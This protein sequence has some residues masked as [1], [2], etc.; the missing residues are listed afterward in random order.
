[1]L[2]RRLFFVFNII[3]VLSLL[4][5]GGDYHIGRA[6]S[7]FIYEGI[8]ITLWGDGSESAGEEKIAY[9][10]S[11]NQNGT[12]QLIIDDELLTSMGGPVTHNRQEMLVTGVWLNE[13]KT[14]QVQSMTLAEGKP[15]SP[16]GIFGPQPW[17]SILCKFSDIPA[18]P[19]DL[20]YFQEMYSS[21][22]PGL[23]HFWRQNS[24]D[25][26]NLEGSGAFGWY[27]LP[28]ERAYYLP[29]GNFDWWTA[30]ADCTAAADPYVDFTPYI[31]INLMF[32]DLLDC[33]A[34]GGGWYACLDGLCQTWRMTWEPP[35]GYQ[36]IGV[37]AHETGHGFGLPHSLGN[38]QQGYDNRWDV[39]SDVWSNGSDPIWGTMGQHTISYHKEMLEWLTPHQVL[40]VN[41]GTLNTITLERL[42]LPHS[43]NYL[44]ARILINDL[45]NNFYTLEV[46]QPTE[47]PIDYDKW[48]PGFAVIIHDIETSRPEPAIVIDRD[49]NC[50]TGDAGAM[51]TPG[52]VFTDI[53]NGITVS[54]DSA[55]ETGYVVTI[56]N[57]F[58]F[59]EGVDIA[60]A[61]QGY[62]G[63]SVP[64]TATVGPV[65]ATTPITYTWEATGFP[66]AVHEGTT[67][68]PI[69]FT[70]EE[71]GTKAITVTASNE[72]GVVSDTHLIEMVSK[73]PI[74]TLSG[75]A[76]SRVGVVNVFTA[77]V[78]PT[79][80]V[81]P[82]TYTWQ[83]SGQMPITHTAGISDAVSYVWDDPGTQVITVTAMNILGSTTDQY[84]L[85]VFMPPD[86]LEITGLEFGEVRGSYTFTATVNP[87]T[88]TVPITY[89]WSV[90]E[91]LAITHTN[92]VLDSATFQWDSPGPHT[93]SVSAT[94]QVGTVVATWLITIY[95]KVYLPIGMRN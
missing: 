15:V 90:D 71:A 18:E 61:T 35:W 88:S 81:Q 68:D 85:L 69:E 54:I 93:I 48:L 27:V 30:A 42:A 17:V 12:I 64:L 21:S 60:G 2:P 26:A 36:N 66:P 16:Q 76:E 80:V 49:G 67:V 65:E 24:Y 45:S 14:L 40:T 56:N 92:G 57:R 52:E 83:A 74:V 63:E 70:W 47:N 58:I 94:N 1:M 59:M 8:F 32:N 6:S 10:L 46:R 38:C 25:L 20:E 55:T 3:A 86:S 29:G 95:I 43:E 33:C 7:P 73:V 13:G 28:H 39:L 62:I 22:Y 4:V 19:N 34:W 51:Y 41:T 11:T 23:D 77:T 78:V 91:Q 75:P 9:Y 53:P 72:G 50:N 87:I 44:G 82:I 5:Q 31:G 84:T 79:D 37:I 89:A